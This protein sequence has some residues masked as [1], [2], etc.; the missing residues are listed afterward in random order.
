M[1]EEV[2][3][4]IKGDADGAIG[5]FG[6]VG[7]ASTNT[8]ARLKAAND[9][10]R[11]SAV[12]LTSIV[13][14]LGL[15]YAASAFAQGV[16]K[17][18]DFADAMDESAQKAGVAT[19]KFSE[20]AYAGRFAGLESDQL[21]KA[22]TKVNDAVIKAASGDTKMKGLLVDTLQVQ[23]KNAAGEVR[24][25]DAVLMDLIEGLSKIENQGIRT[26]KTIEIFG[27]KLGPQLLP[28]INLTR[29][30]VEDLR[31]EAHRLGVVVSDEAGAAAGDLKDDLDRLKA[32]QEGVYNQ[33]ATQM[34]PGLTM[35]SSL[36][37]D[38]NRNAGILLGT[39]LTL[40]EAMAI[41]VGGGELDTAET[42][43]RQAEANLA[44]I[45]QKMREIKE[46][47]DSAVW[48][49]GF[50]APVM[51]ATSALKAYQAEYE[52]TKN[53]VLAANQRLAE[54]A[55]KIAGPAASTARASGGDGGRA[56]AL[57]DEEQAKKTADA[58]RKAAADAAR[59]ANN[60]KKQQ[61]DAFDDRVGQLRLEQARWKNNTD[62]QRR[63]AERMAKEASDMFGD[64]SA[65]HSAALAEIVRIEQRAAEQRRQ[66]EDELRESQVEAALAA[67]EEDRA[68][69]D[70]SLALGL[71]TMEQRL[72]QEL[73]FEGRMYEIKKRAL[74]E[75][76][77]LEALLNPDA[78]PVALAKKQQQLEELE[79]QHLA[80]MGQIKREQEGDK[81][82]PGM[83]MG[84]GL[85]RDVTS[86][87]TS[88]LT[89]QTTLMESLKGLWRGG[90]T[91]FVEEMISKPLAAWVAGQA[92]MT[93]TTLMGVNTRVAAEATGAA[94]TEGV[95]AASVIKI[96]TMKAWQASASVYAAIAGIPFVGPFLAPV[97]AVGAVGAVMAM[98]G[99]VFSAAG[100]FDIP[101]GVNPMVQAHAREMILPARY[102]DVI[103]GLADGGAGGGG[104]GDTFAP[105]IYAMD[106]KSMQQFMRG[107]GG[108]AIFREWSMRRR[109]NRGG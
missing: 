101:S 28:L 32:V 80:R 90:Y 36:W 7:Q 69:A 19:S 67:I 11:E 44:R 39:L 56:Q 23:V 50:G 77:D 34:V 29:Q 22:L 66:I 4:V 21:V 100:G 53:Q 35:M 9:S 83:A 97:M 79:R 99:N 16:R 55:N 60:L 96:I 24:D 33:I 75:R 27:D 45:A 13:T 12:K 73:V 61:R 40:K 70:H 59:D 104:G 47:P 48:F 20:L 92:R 85:E 72:A 5:A 94:M 102:A 76:M 52:R 95:T 108:D 8:A 109:S 105:V 82:A 43:L 71:Q 93:L 1:S 74:E 17:Q 26:A 42:E 63:L 31:E 106:S 58:K 107:P 62:E 103:R 91:T 10:I 88:L 49:A 78:D 6:K 81:A 98:A 15:A 14:G 41:A 65:E 46:D 18:L 51:S 25:A 38:N 86:A 30:G 89:Q 64:K 84:G 3:I 2:K 37:L 68:Q 54:V 87:T 57:L